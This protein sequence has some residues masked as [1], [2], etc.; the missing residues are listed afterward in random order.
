MKQIPYASV[1]ETIMNLARVQVNT[2][3]LFVEHWTAKNA[4][5]AITRLQNTIKHTRSMLT[6]QLTQDG[7]DPELVDKAVQQF[8]HEMKTILDGRTP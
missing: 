5:E 6:T 3:P 8:D 1:E 4:I 7:W 2:S